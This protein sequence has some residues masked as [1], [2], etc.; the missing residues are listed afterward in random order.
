MQKTCEER[1]KVSG[2]RM[3]KE[4]GLISIYRP[5]GIITRS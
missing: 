5:A 1:G 3:G 2:A 4:P